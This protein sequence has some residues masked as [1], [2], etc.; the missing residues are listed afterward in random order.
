MTNFLFKYAVTPILILSMTHETMY[1]D[2]AARM[3]TNTPLM[4]LLY[5]KY[6]SEKGFTSMLRIATW[7]VIR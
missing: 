2:N 7:S 1:A 3:I 4:L 6:N 5:G